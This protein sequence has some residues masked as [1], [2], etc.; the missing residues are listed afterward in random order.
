MPMSE[1]DG[2]SFRSPTFVAQ[3]PGR[4]IPVTPPDPRVIK[5]PE[6]GAMVSLRL[7]PLSPSHL[8]SH[9]EIQSFHVSAN[10]PLAQRHADHAQR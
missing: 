7:Q 1:A 4:R 5:G 2:L 8:P 6:D 3:R 9:Q 10:I